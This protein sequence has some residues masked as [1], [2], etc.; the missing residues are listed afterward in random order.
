M[1]KMYYKD[2]IVHWMNDLSNKDKCID[3]GL[4]SYVCPCNINLRER[5]K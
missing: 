1:R 3:C 4:C 2:A 5:L